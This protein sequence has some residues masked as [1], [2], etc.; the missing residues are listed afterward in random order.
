[1]I[2]ILNFQITMHW[3]QYFQSRLVAALETVEHA[4]GI[5]I[6]EYSRI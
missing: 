2:I 1:M 4:V 3:K 5:S 6:I